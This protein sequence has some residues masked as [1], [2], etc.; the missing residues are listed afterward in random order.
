LI[1]R[2]LRGRMGGLLGMNSVSF[3]EVPFIT[4]LY[5]EE[6]YGSWEKGELAFGISLGK[7]VMQERTG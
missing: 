4:L 7:R 6:M 1:R 2:R 3:E 5:D